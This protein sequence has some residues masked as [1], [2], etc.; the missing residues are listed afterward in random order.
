VENWLYLDD[1]ISIR[2]EFMEEKLNILYV[3]N[4]FDNLKAIGH[5]LKEE[6]Y[7]YRIEHIKS[8]Y[9]LLTYKTNDRIN[10]VI[11][12][13]KLDDLTCL[14]IIKILNA[15]GLN[16]PIILFTASA[17]E[18][19]AIETIKYGYSDYVFKNNFRRLCLVIKKEININR[20]NKQNIVLKEKLNDYKKIDE[21]RINGLEYE[22][23]ENVNFQND[24]RK[25]V[26]NKEF[27]VFYQPQYSIKTGKIVGMEALVRWIHPEKGVISPGKFIP[28][29]EEI[30]LIIPIG[31]FVLYEACKLNKKLQEKGY[32]CETISVNLSAKQFS[33]EGLV[34]TIQKVLK[35]TGLDPK[36][37]VL[38]ITET[39]VMKNID[40][41]IKILNKIKS[42]GIKI[43]LD[44]FGTGYSSLNYLKDLPIDTLKID[45]SFMDGIPSNIKEEAIAKTIINL[46][47]IL[48][49]DIIAEGVENEKQL[50]FLKHEN[51]DKVQGFIFSK[52]ISSSEVEQKFRQLK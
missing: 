1:K 45:K 40:Y 38:E 43:A 26:R 29:V 28:T 24:L 5:E 36:W 12:E 15:L 13:Y 52:P 9:D 42:M 30:G 51:C 23:L 35:E 34:S 27:T 22:D 21:E 11:T 10:L 32:R 18:E 46:A 50:E 41:T 33:E 37:L 44:D 31:E 49:L 16:V 4:S 14:E 19:N 47:H 48:N 3:D 2:G 7:I 39:I 17:S 25:A 6:G 8:R 20:I